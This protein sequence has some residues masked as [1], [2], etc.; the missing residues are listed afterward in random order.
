MKRIAPLKE[1]YLFLWQGTTG[2]KEDM[3]SGGFLDKAAAY[4]KSVGC[5]PEDRAHK[6]KQSKEK[7]IDSGILN[8]H[9]NLVSIQM[10]QAW[11]GSY[12]K[13][14]CTPKS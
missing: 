13:K 3:I 14:N 12:L 10:R 11:P 5:P 4:R 2:K 7:K 9:A 8:K 1:V 6:S